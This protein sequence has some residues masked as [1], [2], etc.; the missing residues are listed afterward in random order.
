MKRND[1]VKTL[2]LILSII[3]ATVVSS[4]LLDLVTG[5]QIAENA[6]KREELAAQQ[7]AGVLNKVL[8]GSQSFEDITSTLTIDP[9][10]G[11]SVVYKETSG[12]GY[13]FIASSTASPMKDVVT[14]TVGVDMNGQITGLK[15]EFANPGD[16]KVN[17]AT[18]NSF[19]GKDS[20]LA[21][22]VLTGGATVSSNA[23]K[24]AVTAGFQ[25]LAANELMK[26]AA[27][28]PEQVFEEL[29]PTVFNGFV[30]GAD[31]TVSGNIYQAYKSFNNTVVVAYVNK[32]ETK[33]LALASVSGVVTVYAAELLDEATQAYKLNDVTAD[34]SDVVT[35]V[36]TLA[37]N[38]ITTKTDSLT[39]KVNL[40]YSNATDVTSID[41]NTYGSLVAAVSFTVE[42]ETY[43]AYY[44]NSINGFGNHIMDIYVVLD[45][46]GK[47]V[48][49]D[50][51]TLFFE[52]EYFMTKPNIS[53]D[54]YQGGFNGL[55]GETFDGSQA[56]MSGATMTSNA[57]KQTMFDVFAQ[58]ASQGGNN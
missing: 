58:Y 31:L 35:E 7:A 50:I 10:S 49:V 45:S 6:V 26:A 23:I 22:I 36:E 25:V 8:P 5:K 53:K 9:A 57:T 51:V 11:V 48:K 13:V 52:E 43:Y 4:V 2:I 24:A 41:I 3:A 27:K 12:K 37:A 28:T 46:E 17:D 56:M 1:L 39:N 30:K 21:D 14:V 38:N 47:V 15:E 44:S 18:I 34:N 20:T 29:L 32:G 40:Y 42:G 33:L 55:T 19:V 16:Y 54:Q